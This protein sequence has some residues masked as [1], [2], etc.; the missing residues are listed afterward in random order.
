VVPMGFLLTQYTI[1]GFDASA[2]VSEE[3]AGASK[4]AARGI[5]QSIFYS[6]IGGWLILLAFLWAAPE[7]KVDEITTLAGDYL[8]F[9]APAIFLTSLSLTLVKII[10]VITTIGQFFC[11]MSC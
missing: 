11:G 3:T 2:H 1:T 5:W 9:Y 8:F 4:S 10:M 6:A 7:S